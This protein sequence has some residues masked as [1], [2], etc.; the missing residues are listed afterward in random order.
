MTNTAPE[1]L[2]IVELH[3]ENVMRL[4]AVTIR[5]DPDDSVVV[6][7]GRNAQGKAQPLSEPVLTPTGWRTMG[8]IQPGDQVVGGDGKPV[9]VLSV[10]PQVEREV[11]RVTFS[12][13]SSTRCSPDHLWSVKK[14]QG[15]RRGQS[16]KIE[17]TATLAELL[18][19]GLDAGAGGPGRWE[20]PLVSGP[21]TFEP[22]T[23]DL[24]ID[25]WALGVILGDGHITSRGEVKLS[26]DEEVLR[27]LGRTPRRPASLRSDKIAL[28]SVSQWRHALLD[29]GLA[30]THSWDKFV[31]PQY[32]LAGVD[33]R[34]ALLAGLLDTDGTPRSTGAE[35]SSTS[36]S[37]VDAV[38]ELVQSLGGTARKSA[39]RVTRYT[40]N[41]EPREG[42]ASWRV[43]IATPFNPFTLSR[44]RDGWSAP[45]G[46]VIGRW[47]SSVERVE[48]ED[49]QCIRVDSADGLYLTRGYIVTHNTSVL[50]AIA[51]ALGGAA[52][53]KGISNPIR[54]G[55]DDA[56]VRLDL[57]RFIVTRTW[58]AAA[59][60]SSLTV[61]TSDGAKFQRPQQF[62]D[63]F[64]GSLTF[65][66]LAFMR[67]PSKDQVATLLGL[68]DL[69]FDLDAL[70]D[71]HDENFVKRTEAGREADRLAAH[72]AS[73]TPPPEGTPTE[74]VSTEALLAEHREATAA[75]E[76][77]R[78]ALGR[79]EQA[80]RDAD[81][82]R[83][84][85]AEIDAEMERLRVARAETEAALLAAATANADH[86]A[87]HESIDVP[88]IDDI[89]RRLA[90][91]EQVN[92]AVRAGI[93]FRQAHADAQAAKEEV[94]GLTFL[95]EEARGAKRR[96]VARAAMPIKGLS[97]DLDTRQVVYNDM[98]LPQ[99]SAAEQLRVSMAIGMAANPTIRVMLITDGSLLDGDSMAAVKAMAAEHGYQVWIERIDVGDPATVI[100]E[101]GEVVDRGRYNEMRGD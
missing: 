23:V 25:P 7:G 56:E 76:A 41:G 96:A 27:R 60:R 100:I 32:L 39:P 89:E 17:R 72:A 53:V 82:H 47:I 51:A 26:T 101:D 21:V 29:L 59:R 35:F 57:G 2:V 74:E 92:A 81:R 30:G 37:L 91:A 69:P 42:R 5:P 4:R 66:P 19:V 98:P 77:A 70:D 62:L 49:C 90:A 18:A 95:I 84:R 80:T 50:R 67:Q 54:V 11:W 34:M 44:K 45:T 55:E 64:L 46:R 52:G 22:D 71:E 87:E 1:P 15:S 93:A 12:D 68:I 97:F 88:D 14:W 99:C 3:A 43:G 16:R 31:P 6:I 48:D 94:E 63:E 73:L 28:S 33:Q 65:D 78:V 36:E 9:T 75:A 13:G 38:V 85:L 83:E 86:L 58:D 20:V 10:H 61:T 40:H 79:A 24:P 8:A